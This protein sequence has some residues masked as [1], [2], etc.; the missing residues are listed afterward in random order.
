MKSIFNIAIFMIF[1]VTLHSCSPAYVSSQPSYSE[2]V[3]PMS[4]SNSHVWVGENW[5]YNRQTRS[6]NHNNGYW[7]LPNRGKTYQQGKWNNNRN[8]YYWSRGRWR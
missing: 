4:P 1:F 8:G 6:Y 5:I 7:A 2:E 3:R